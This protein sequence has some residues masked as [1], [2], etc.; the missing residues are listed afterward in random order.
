ML[1]YSRMF[2]IKPYFI[3]SCAIIFAL[4]LTA[5]GCGGTTSTTSPATSPSGF[6]NAQPPAGQPATGTP[7]KAAAVSKACEIPPP[8][9][10][11]PTTTIANG[12]VNNVPVSKIHTSEVAIP[13]LWA[14]AKEWTSDAILVS[15]YHGQGNSYT[16]TDPKFR[17]HFGNVRGA[18][19]A[20]SAHFYSP[21]KN[22]DVDLAYIDE[23][24]GGSI[25][26]TTNADTAKSYV[27]EN[28]RQVMNTYADYASLISSCQVYEITRANG[29]DPIANYEIVFTGDS[30]SAHKYPGRATWILEE[31]SRTD[32]DGGKEIMGKVVNTYLI[33]AHTGDLL[34][35][36][37]DRVYSF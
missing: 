36:Q 24:V 21:S 9:M 12:T 32:N 22:E 19:W 15:G 25:P 34:E 28:S 33:D 13:L 4:T 8:T 16:P 18:L 17:S 3:S 2:H 7:Q 26:Q 14:K 5:A 30:R 35:K 31:R 6:N 23:E 27:A 1:Q 20:W 11:A 29:F 10:S 37:V